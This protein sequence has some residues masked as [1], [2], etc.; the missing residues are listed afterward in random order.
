MTRRPAVVAALAAALLLA[1]GPAE[2]PAPLPPPVDYRQVT[3]FG[4]VVVP[5]AGEL[6]PRLA[7][8]ASQLR[9]LRPGSGF[10]LRGVESRRLASGQTLTCDMKRGVKATTELLD[11]MDGKGKV[12]FRFALE[13]DGRSVFRTIVTT[14]PNQLF[15]CEKP[16]PD[17]DRLLI[18][19]GAR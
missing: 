1:A 6:D 11:A 10:R 12:R 17:G 16:L 8:V 9:K 14:P 5:D 7:K 19:I 18:G 4:V 3:L 13:I 15:F 2:K